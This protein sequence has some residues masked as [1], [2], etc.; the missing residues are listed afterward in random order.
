MNAENNQVHLAGIVAGPCVFSHKVY[1][2]GFYR[3]PLAVPR[4]SQIRDLLPVTFSERLLEAG[5]VTEGQTLW[6]RG[7]L[8]SYNQ[9]EEGRSR[10]LL[11]VFAREAE[12]G[13]AGVFRNGIFL[14]G[15]V[16][17]PPVYRT[18]PFGREI[19]DVL[20]AVNRAYHK[21]DYIP[22]ILWG[23]NARFARELPVGQAVS[24]WGRV[25]SRVYVKRR[26][27][28]DQERTAYEVSVSRL[29]CEENH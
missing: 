26:E 29:E 12:E 8:R 27:D 14:Q 3:F 16:C 4:L 2:E 20:V 25:Q 7:Q 1:G 15:F 13:P 11:T 9:L 10:L 19:T 28:G 21:S 22:C 24:L 23:R 5:Q 6:V 17:K 18:T